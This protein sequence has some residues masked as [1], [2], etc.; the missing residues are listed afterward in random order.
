MDRLVE[1]DW[2]RPSRSES[3]AGKIAEDGVMATG[4]LLTR[5]EA[6]A[7]VR[8]KPSFFSKVVNGKVK[9]LPPLPVVRIGRRQFFRE[10]SLNQ[11]INDVEAK[12]CNAAH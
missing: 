1:R 10:E 11:W 6:M 4:G 12:S 9:G 7:W 5:D 3:P 8:L 2:R